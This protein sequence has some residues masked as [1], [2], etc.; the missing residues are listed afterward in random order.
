MARSRCFVQLSHPGREH[1]PDRGTE[2]TWNTLKHSN[3]RQFMQLRGQWVAE[4]RG[5]QTDDPNRSDGGHSTRL[6]S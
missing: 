2:K 1:E 4:D 3:A 5:K 6:A